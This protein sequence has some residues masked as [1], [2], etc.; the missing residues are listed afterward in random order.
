MIP[1]IREESTVDG[2]LYSWPF[3][4]DVIGMG[5]H[6]GL[7]PRPGSRTAPRTWDEYLQNARTVVDPAPRPSARPST[8]TAG[9]RSRR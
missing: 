3:L 9:A 2:K 7:T 6:S 5:W 1:S 8:P 4:L